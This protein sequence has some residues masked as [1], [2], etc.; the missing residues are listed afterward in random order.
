MLASKDRD[1]VVETSVP[2]LARRAR[3]TIEQCEE[4][5]SKLKAPDPYSRT[6]DN[7]GRRI[8]DVDG[9]FLVL[10]HEKYR[11][12][13]SIEER[14]RKDAE[15]ARR[16]RE[17]KKRERE[18]RDGRDG[19]R[20]G[21]DESRES[22]HTNAD[23]DP[24]TD[25]NTSTNGQKKREPGAKRP[26][27]SSP[28]RSRD[29]LTPRQLSFLEVMESTSILMAK[30]GELLISEAIDDPVG[31]ASRIGDEM[32]YPGVEPAELKRAANWT[33]ENKAK[34]KV[35]IGA[36][37]TRWLDKAQER[38]TTNGGRVLFTA[39][40]QKLKRDRDILDRMEKHYAQK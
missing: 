39:A 30:K 35:K 5:L 10:N 18:S 37:L 4:A 16:Y 20:D 32:M 7:E 36:F 25:T 27:R 21:R 1:G 9:G 22:L 26:K 12:K 34:A 3:V 19:E 15:R 24:Y 6:K 14:R 17:R 23:T 40:E 28:G 31:F 33:F 29:D 2:G 11:E 38:T 13:D 8:E